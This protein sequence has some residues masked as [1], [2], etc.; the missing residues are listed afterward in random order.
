MIAR[1]VVGPTVPVTVEVGAP[2]DGLLEAVGA[3][4]FEAA[5]TSLGERMGELGVPGRPVVELRS[6][7]SPRAVRVRVHDVIRPFPPALMSHAWLAAFGGQHPDAP[8]PAYLWRPDSVPEVPGGAEQRADQLVAFLSQLVFHVV[9]DRPGCLVSAAQAAAYG[10]GREPDEPP[11]VDQLG[12]VIRSLLDLGVSIADRAFVLGCVADGRE[13]GRSP[14]D[15]VEAAYSRLRSDAVTVLLNP[16]DLDRLAPGSAGTPT[17][18]YEH[19]VSEDVQRAFAQ[20]E[21]QL[22]VTLGV[23]IPRPM[24]EASPDPL[25]EGTAAVRVNDHVSPPL[26]GSLAWA[27]YQHLSSRAD[28]LVGIEDVEYALVQL[29]D[30][31]PELVSAT[32]ASLSLGDLTRALRALVEEH[33][34]VRNLVALLERLLQ[35]D[36]IPADAFSHVVLDD[37]LPVGGTD[38]ELGWRVL[39]AFVRGGT[40]LRSYF[41]NRYSAGGAVQVI[42]ADVDVERR[43][44]EAVAAGSAGSEAGEAIRDAVWRRVGDPSGNL[45]ILA[46]TPAGR[47]ALREILA[48]ELPDQAVITPLELLPDARI[49]V[50][51]SVAANASPVE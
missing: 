19:G 14:E 11:P 21:E 22:F 16:V 47:A 12:F 31:V 33:V 25:P 23:R 2:F 48:P 29:G 28:R 35:Y 49:E 36:S 24:L 41:T 17:L 40:G 42:A 45:P 34:P 10:A 51:E 38:V 1:L 44:L 30:A 8:M 6:V 46:T 18:V 27:A 13:C 3:R 39:L 7:P 4:P 43:A 9:F 5:E 50:I 37:R 15:T 20:M 32:L 26:R